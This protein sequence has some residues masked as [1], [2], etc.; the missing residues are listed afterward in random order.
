MCSTLTEAEC[1]CRQG[2][3]APSSP[4]Y[5][6]NSLGQFWLPVTCYILPASKEIWRRG[7]RCI[8]AYLAAAVQD[9]FFPNSEDSW[10]HPN[11]LKA[12]KL[13]QL[14]RDIPG[15]SHCNSICNSCFLHRWRTAHF[16]LWLLGG[17]ICEGSARPGK[18]NKL[19]IHLSVQKICKISFL[20]WQ[21]ALPF[22]DVHPTHVWSVLLA[23]LGCPAT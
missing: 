13:S 12:L 14:I 9:I 2:T 15:K 16:L 18:R 5:C 7:F 3:V 23:H 1:T 21:F 10:I 11:I 17:E 6:T 4:V 22:E 19:L 20:P 8:C